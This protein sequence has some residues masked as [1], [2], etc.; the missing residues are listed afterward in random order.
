[1]PGGGGE[2]CTETG[3]RVHC[4]LGDA[5]AMYKIAVTP[6]QLGLPFAQVVAFAQKQ[7]RDASQ[8]HVCHNG[9]HDM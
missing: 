2:V 9:R 7:Q 5:Q 1:M 6:L 4:N 8:G 3:N